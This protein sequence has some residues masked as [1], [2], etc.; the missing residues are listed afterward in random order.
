MHRPTNEWSALC[1]G[2]FV[3]LLY[4]MLL[5]SG[6]GSQRVLAG[7]IKDVDLSKIPFM[8]GVY[9]SVRQCHA[10]RAYLTASQFPR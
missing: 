3:V 2:A 4:A 1:F 7:L 5:W 8:S 9:A 10:C 6:P